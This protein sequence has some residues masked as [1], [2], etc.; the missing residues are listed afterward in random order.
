MISASATTILP[1]ALNSRRF[2]ADKPAT[3]PNKLEGIVNREG[4]HESSAKRYIRQ[5]WG[6]R[7][8]MRHPIAVSSTYVHL[9][10]Q[11]QN[12]RFT[13]HCISK[14]DLRKYFIKRKLVEYGFAQKFSIDPGA[15]PNLM[16]E[17]RTLGVFR[18]MIL[19]GL[20]SLC[21]QFDEMYRQ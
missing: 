10:M 9:R 8:N 11:V 15:A 5:A 14:T 4:I 12:S 16:R 13:I 7:E 21:S 19:P 3:P 17:L 18:S 6:I 20:D 2:S 1:S